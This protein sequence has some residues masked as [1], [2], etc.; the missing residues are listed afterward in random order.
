MCRQNGD[1]VNWGSLERKPRSPDRTMPYRRTVRYA[2][3]LVAWHEIVL[4]EPAPEWS[5][6]Y[7]AESPRLLIPGSRCIEAEQRGQRFF[8]DALTPLAV[9]PEVPYRTRQPHVGQ[10]SVVLVFESGDGGALR[11]TARLRLCPTA[12]WQL[13]GCRTAL[14]RGVPDRLGLEET[15]LALLPA[16]CDSEP[17]PDNGKVVALHQARRRIP[18]RSADRAVERARELLACDP[19]S[20]DSLHEIARAVASSPFHLARRFKQANGIGLHGYR[21]RLRMAL[22]LARLCDGEENLTGL[23]LDLGY[24][25]HS[26]F[27]ATF[28]SHFGASPSNARTVL[29]SSARFR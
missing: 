2:S 13:A 9:T 11:W 12:Q 25:S 18:D 6:A 29:A 21:T 14:D 1:R 4:T 26:H 23:A 15:L 10:R 8:C 22:A 17:A 7:M 3:P 19:S 16:T 24:S 5:D 28:R 20:A 27:T